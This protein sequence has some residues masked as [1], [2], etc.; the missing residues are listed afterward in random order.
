MV[1]GMSIWLTQILDPG[2]LVHNI[3]MLLILAAIAMPTLGSARWFALL[4]GIVGAVGAAVVARDPGNLFWWLLIGLVAIIRLIAGRSW[5]FGHA[6]T[7]DEE[8]FHQRVVP[9]LSVGRVR[10]L[11][12][13]G[14]WREVVPG[15]ALSRSGERVAELCFV[16]RGTV[17]IVVEG[18]RVG[19][20]GPGTLVGEAGLS[21]GDPA[22]ADAIC[23]TPVRYLGFEATRLYRLL[24][25]HSDL[26]D[27]ME[28]AIERSLRDKLVQSN[29][30]VAHRDG[31][32]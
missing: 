20:C 8:L 30:A 2:L 19:A 23:A 27:A 3:A 7:R 1:A 26:Q 21:T 22:T 11:L 32:R 17:D 14:R 15:T 31:A 13:A 29:A 25:D 18:K 28:L 16:T 10:R 6:L 9:D 24:D 4:A 5:R 12:A